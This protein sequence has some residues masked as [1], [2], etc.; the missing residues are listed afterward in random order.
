MDISCIS[1]KYQVRRITEENILEVLE[2][3]IENPLYYKHCPPMVTL[4]SI[5]NDLKNLP[6]SKTLEDKFY[7]GFYEKEELLAVI[8]LILEYP[9][10]QTVFIGF[11]M[12]NKNYQRKGIG[13]SIINEVLEYFM[14]NYKYVRLG[15]VSG[16]KESES[17]WLKNQFKPTHLVIKGDAYSI[18]VME[19]KLEE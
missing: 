11:F 9:N 19:R 3:C 15:Y 13:T 4:E 8:D 18:V 12:M 7:V 1:K 5:K 14:S 16:N 17:F 2:L 6:P 10:N